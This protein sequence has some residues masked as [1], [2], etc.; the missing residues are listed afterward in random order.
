MGEV[1]KENSLVSSLNNK[2]H[3]C[4]FDSAQIKKVAVSAL[5]VSRLL[6]NCGAGAIKGVGKAAEMAWYVR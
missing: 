6:A 2:F 5:P 3:T 1:E 4:I